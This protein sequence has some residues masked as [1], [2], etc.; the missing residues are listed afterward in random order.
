LSADLASVARIETAA[1]A[2]WPTLSS[3]RDGSWVVRRAEGHTGRSNSLNV[4]DP[5]DDGDIDR[6]LGAAAALYRE[7]ELRPLLRRTP[8]TPPA[9]LA[10]V[11]A[12]GWTEYGASVV[13]T[14]ALDAGEL[15]SADNAPAARVDR[16]WLEAMAA[17]MDFSEARREA[18]GRKLE[19]LE[20]EAG[21]LLARDAAGLP[22]ASALSVR[23]GDVVG[24]YEI[25]VAPAMRRR[26]LG[27][28]MVREALGWARQ[29]GAALAF[30][31]VTADNAPAIALY[32]R[33]GFTEH[34]RYAYHAP[35]GD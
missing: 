34:Y 35:G 22:V 7:R 27:G 11:G 21:F 32:R 24:L 16:E 6:R 10:H 19:R 17:F 33:L 13:M 9:L 25:G 18:I 8:L 31:Q 3:L 30:L 29:T 23:A 15:A 14:R 28:A 4:L 20:N 1:L 12:N 5:A 2:T 26:G